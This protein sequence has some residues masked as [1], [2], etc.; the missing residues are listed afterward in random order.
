MTGF[1]SPIIWQFAYIFLTE[2]L[3]EEVQDMYLALIISFLF[4]GIVI[5]PQL[6]SEE[7]SNLTEEVNSGWYDYNL[8]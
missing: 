5:V 6:A 7:D 2:Q 1:D 8:H 4:A 3:R